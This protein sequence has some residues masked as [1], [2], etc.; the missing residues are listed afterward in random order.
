MPSKKADF[1]FEQTLC[2]LETLV[3]TMESGDLTLEQS[4]SA[5]E[6]G[7]GLTRGC[8]KALNEAEQKVQLLVE[9]NDHLESRPFDSDVKE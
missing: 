7:I 4:L 2:E 9:T 3:E 5:F 1:A 8:Q 6:K